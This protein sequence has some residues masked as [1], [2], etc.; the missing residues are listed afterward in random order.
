MRWGSPPVLSLRPEGVRRGAGGDVG[1]ERVPFAPDV[2]AGAVH[3]DRE[4]EHQAA[5]RARAAG[6]LRQL[7]GGHPL[8]E[9]VVARPVVIERRPGERALTLGPWPRAPPC[10]APLDLRAEPR[11]VGGSRV[12]RELAQAG[13]E[14]AREGLLREGVE[15]A[16]FRGGDRR[17]IG[18]VVLA[19]AGQLLA[20]G[21]VLQR[22][23]SLGDSPSRPG[24]RVTSMY[25]SFQKRRLAGE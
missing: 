16:P 15:D 20:E 6:G 13:R 10:P 4:V 18:Q 2:V 19:Q 1:R 7:L 12:R 9:Q 3:P 23:A 22:L 5:G 11:V 14:R 17:V 25:V 8:D 24:A 21:G